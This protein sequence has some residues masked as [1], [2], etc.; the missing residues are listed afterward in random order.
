[1]T[2]TCNLVQRRIHI[3]CAILSGRTLLHCDATS[4]Q[5]GSNLTSG[6]SPVMA[7]PESARAV[8][9]WFSAFANFAYDPGSGLKSNFDR[10]ATR[11]GWG[12]KLK[13]KRWTQCQTTCFTALYGG[14][15]DLNKLEKWQDLC[16][17]V[18]IADPAESISGCKKVIITLWSIQDM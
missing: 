18:H 3:S 8:S 9:D 7:S 17:E 2:H 13:R 10:L 5:R 15:A 14:D 1:M 4:T 16:R 12:Q 6:F 11:R